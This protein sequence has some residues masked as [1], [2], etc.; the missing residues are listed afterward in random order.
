LERL[1]QIASNITNYAVSAVATPTA[2][3]LV[4]GTVGDLGTVFAGGSGGQIF[5][6][7]V[8]GAFTA[9]IGLLGPELQGEAVV[10]A[11]LADFMSNVSIAGANPLFGD[12]Y[13]PCLEEKQY[14]D[15]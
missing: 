1:G 7:A 5:N 9:A 11:E 15:Y 13:S 10:M 4:G 8:A 12:P 3:A 14:E 6:N 2:S